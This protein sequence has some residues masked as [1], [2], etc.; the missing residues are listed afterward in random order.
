MTVTPQK[1][2]EI[3]YR[4]AGKNSYYTAIHRRPELGHHE[5]YTS[6]CLSY[7]KDKVRS[8]GHGFVVR[9]R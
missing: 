7:L 3:N 6:K 5:V 4:E 8:K 2:F 9:A 1:T